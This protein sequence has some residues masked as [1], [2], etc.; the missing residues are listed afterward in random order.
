MNKEINMDSQALADL[1]VKEI[2]DNKG[3]DIVCM[4]V[5]GLSNVT[6]FMV[7][8]TATST[9]HAKAVASKVAEKAKEAGN[10]A[11]G[12]E[13]EDTGEWVLLDLGDVVVHVM[14]ENM[15][16]LY[17]LEKLWNIKSVPTA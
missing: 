4:N 10:A 15:R 17:Q 8:V 11:I 1:V 13:G 7:V 6:D 2:D 9:R 5:R 3:K 14:L 12:M 16:A